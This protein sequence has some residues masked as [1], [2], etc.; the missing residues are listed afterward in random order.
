MRSYR[1]LAVGLTLLGVLGVSAVTAQKQRNRERAAP[2]PA[3]SRRHRGPP[4]AGC[5]RPPGA[6]LGRTGQARQGRGPRRRGLPLPR[7]GRGERARRLEGEEPRDPQGRR[8]EGGQARVGGP[9]GEGGRAEH[10]RARDRAQRRGRHAQG[11]GRRDADGFDSRRAMSRSRSPTWPAAGPN[12]PRRQG[13]GPARPAERAAGRRAPYQE[14]FPAAA[15]DAQGGAWIAYV[16][17]KPRGPEVL[18]SFT[19]AAQGL[20]RLRLPRR[21]ATRSACSGSPTARPATRST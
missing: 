21:A 7:G 9:R 13:R 6:S 2:P 16:V 12:L 3:R 5:R 14:D 17:H 18:E 15:A 11:A 8:Q 10:H 1:S 19:A 4:P 20:R